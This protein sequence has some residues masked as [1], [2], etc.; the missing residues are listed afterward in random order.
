[1]LEADA[2]FTVFPHN[3]SEYESTNDLPEPIEDPD[4]L[5]D[6]VNEWLQYFSQ[7]HPRARG[8]Y[9][10][11]SVLL[12][13]REPFP[14]VVKN[15]ASWFRKTKL[16][17]WKSSLQSKKPVALGW[18]L[19]LTSMM[20][21]EVLC[22]EISLCIR[23]IPVG[24]HWK[25]ISI[26]AQGSVPPEQQ[27]KALHLFFNELD[28][29]QAKLLL[30]SLYAN[31]LAPGHKF[32]LHI[33]MRLVPELDSILNTKG[34]NNAERLWACQNTWQADKV[35]IIKTWEIKL[36]NHYNLHIKMS[37][38]MA[39][40]SLWHPTNNKFNLFHSIDRHWIKKCHVLMVLK[41][42]ESQARAMI[43]GMLPY[44]QW[45][46]G[47]DN[48]KKGQIAKWF[49]PAVWARVADAYWDPAKECIKNTSNKML[50]VAMVDN[51]NLYWA[52]E[53]PPQTW[54]CPRGNR[55]NLKKNH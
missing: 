22:G 15:T 24:L 51:D 16:G 23:L 10:Y 26:R 17:I 55:F 28:A 36:L 42:A 47:P 21:K 35:K 53:K 43:A 1:M 13:F 50:T 41:S 4:M 37:L 19:F 49:K 5:P 9:T 48:Q 30:M 33:C 54:H 3:L 8:G 14:K 2:H 40:M 25:M 38:Q 20:D 11:T 34:R 46:Y 32:L 29:A 44:L 7:A 39:M 27:V 6:D 31:N 12:G 52:V 45:K 18:L